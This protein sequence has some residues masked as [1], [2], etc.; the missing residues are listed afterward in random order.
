MRETWAMTEDMK[1][2]SAWVRKILIRIYGPGVEQGMW[3]IRTN[4]ELRELCKDIAIETNIKK[5][6]MEWI[7]H[8]VR[9]DQGGTVKKIFESKPEESRRRG[10][11]RLRWLEDKEKDL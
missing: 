4:R 2:L 11:P 8:V 7:E 1:K 9:M 3:R 10:N 5:K 6:K